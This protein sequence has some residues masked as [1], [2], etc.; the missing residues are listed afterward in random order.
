M[1]SSDIPLRLALFRHCNSLIGT[2]LTVFKF[3]HIQSDNKLPARPT[4]T[5]VPVIKV[6]DPT[7]C[8]TLQSQPNK[9]MIYKIGKIA[10]R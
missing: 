10:G 9:V 6:K 3:I 7:K 4:S 8:D 2:Q 5:N 1:S